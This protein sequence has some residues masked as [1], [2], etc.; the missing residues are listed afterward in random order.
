MTSRNWLLAVVLSTSVLAGC[1][2]DDSGEDSG[3]PEAS[4]AVESL[5]ACDEVWVAGETL[6]DDYDGCVIQGNEIAVFSPG[7]VPQRRPVR[8]VRRHVLRRRRRHHRGEPERRHLQ[9]PEVPEVHGVL[10]TQRGRRAATACI[11]RSCASI[12]DDVACS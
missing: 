10:L 6:P 7:D 3:Q 9:R 8:H 5:P 12:R 1:G 2:G 11:R 4:G